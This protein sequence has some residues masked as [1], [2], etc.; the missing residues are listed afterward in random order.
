[1]S[2]LMLNYKYTYI[3]MRVYSK[4]IMSILKSIDA[5]THLIKR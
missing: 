2:T 1:M 3:Y 4:L 5:Y